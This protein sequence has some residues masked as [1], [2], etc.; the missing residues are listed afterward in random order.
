MMKGV[1]LF[2][3]VFILAWAT[4]AHA[5]KVVVLTLE[6]VID[7]VAA[8]YISRG[9]A[10]AEKEGAECLVLALDT[11]GGVDRS[12]RIIVQKILAA[13]VPV[14]V[15]ISPKGGRAA[16]AGTFITLAG[17][18]AAMSPGTAI[19][20]AHPVEIG[21]ESPVAEKITNDAA[22]YI[23]TIALGR[24]RNAAWADSA[25]RW[26]V[27]ITEQEALSK[28]VIDLVAGDVNALLDSLDGKE[29]EAAGVKRV[30]HTKGSAL[31]NLTMNARESF[32][33]AVAHPNIAYVLFL[34]GIY[35]VIYELANPGAIL[36]GVA[37]GIALI[38]AFVAFETLS[39]NLA[40][41]LLI[42]FAVLLFVV[43]IKA[44]THGIL[45]VGGIV[46]L[47]L[48]SFMLFNPG[49][50]FYRLSIWLILTMVAVT[51]AFFAWIVASGV[52][53]LSKRVKSGAEGLAGRKGVAK[54][55]LA[56]E[57][58]V[59]VEGEDWNAYAEEGEIP[60]G[61]KVEVVAVEGLKVKVR[62]AR[63]S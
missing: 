5:G 7:P 40:G 33:H 3:S 63:S 45:T 36:P 59:L 38:L 28:H 50:S 14:A 32:L 56:K 34:I 27:S 42:L 62:R 60:A 37:G 30:L 41:L 53:A 20:A 25:V 18:V 11:P 23:K 19:G 9:I 49:T 57:G 29:V 17:H 22:A 39:I 8:Q 55:A 4:L 48:G 12:M 46:A 52:R 16:S 54:T 24:G 2:V 15:Y 31:I 26:S 6:G 35:G 13:K 43:D 1:R 58:I 10:T 21:K 44:P 61:E 51:T 47:T